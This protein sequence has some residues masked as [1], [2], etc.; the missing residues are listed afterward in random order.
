MVDGTAESRTLDGRWSVGNRVRGIDQGDRGYLLRQGTHGRGIVGIAEIVKEPYPEASWRGDGSQ[1]QY[2]DVTWLE[3]VPLAD[4]LTIEELK[5][6]IPA[7]KWDSVYSS[8]RDITEHGG[9]LQALWT[10]RVQKAPPLP[11][12]LQGAGFGSAEQNRKVEK[13]AIRHAT[14]QY[15]AAGYQVKSV[16][17][18][19]CGWD[20]TVTKGDE[21]IHVEVKGV[22]GSLVRFFLTANEYKAAAVDSAWLLVVVTNALSN[23]R[24]WF[25]MTG[26]RAMSYSQPALYQVRVPDTDLAELDVSRPW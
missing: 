6:A 8:G 4:M 25:K 16:E 21:E 23:E 11:R 18:D 14:M 20:L 10:G 1:A 19:K 2:V 5:A 13:A 7:F 26:E 9:E 3:C 12:V 24:Q 15:K 22:A 17:A